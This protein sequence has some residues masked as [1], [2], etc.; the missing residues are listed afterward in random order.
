MAQGNPGVIRVSLESRFWARVHKTPACWLWTGKQQGRICSTARAGEPYG[1]LHMPISNKFCYAH[2]VSWELHNGTIP[3]GLQVCHHCDNRLCVRPDHLYIGTQG[4]NLADASRRGRMS[5]KLSTVKAR[6]IK[7]ALANG[8]TA[9]SIAN[10]YN[11][12]YNSIWS[13]K[14][15][16]SWRHA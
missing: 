9:Q 5:K 8:E 16:L 3:D 7:T 11:V 1:L 12:W 14:K 10:R 6:E 4:D 2:R 13:I 15:G